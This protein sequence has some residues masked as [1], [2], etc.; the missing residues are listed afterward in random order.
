MPP[1]LPPP[2]PAFRFGGGGGGGGRGGGRGGGFLGGGQAPSRRAPDSTPWLRTTGRGGGRTAATRGACVG[3]GCPRSLTQAGRPATKATTTAAAAAPPWSGEVDTTR[4]AGDY[5]GDY[6]SAVRRS[7]RWTPRCNNTRLRPAGPRA[8]APTAACLVT[9]VGRSGTMHTSSVLSGLGWNV[10]HDRR[11]SPLC[12]CPGDDGSASHMYSFRR[13][14][15]CVYASSPQLTHLFRRVVHQTRHPLAYINSRVRGGSLQFF[16]RVNLL[17]PS[18]TALMMGAA[19]RAAVAKLA[20][21]KWVLQNTYVG[22]FA[23]WQF[24]VEAATTNA[25]KWVELAHRCGLRERPRR[26]RQRAV[27]RRVWAG[28]DGA[29]RADQPRARRQGGARQEARRA[30]GDGAVELDVACAAEARP[31]VCPRRNAPRIA[32]RVRRRA[33]AAAPAASTLRVC[34]AQR[35][36]AVGLRRAAVRIGEEGARVRAR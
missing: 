26:R 4:R 35:R 16:C 7:H 22:T 31:A 17:R 6:C 30:R 28:R 12:P 19:G 8:D 29:R 25:S 1:P 18:L 24:A 13:H 36:V 15:R 27:G 14:P 11:S 10:D 2:L 33:A 32:V 34:G 5:A 20:L 21:H 9:G 23:D 3:R